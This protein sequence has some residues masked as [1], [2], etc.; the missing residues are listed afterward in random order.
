M[1]DSWKEHWECYLTTKFDG[2]NPPKSFIL[3]LGDLDFCIPPLLVVNRESFNAIKKHN[4]KK[5]I[6]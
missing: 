1:D 4:A 5:G 3:D 2:K 6:F